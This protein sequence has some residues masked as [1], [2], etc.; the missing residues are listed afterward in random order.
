MKGFRAAGT[1]QRA[2]AAARGGAK[3]LSPRTSLAAAGPLATTRDAAGRPSGRRRGPAAG[4][5]LPVAPAPTL[6]LQP[7]PRSS[8]TFAG[9]RPAALRSSLMGWP[10]RTALMAA[11][12][13]LTTAAVWAA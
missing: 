6:I 11:D 3:S 2:P 12:S 7:Q 4:M 13:S 10:S 5:P 1:F 8:T 9:L